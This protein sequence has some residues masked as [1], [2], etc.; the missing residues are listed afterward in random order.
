MEGEEL[1]SFL[2]DFFEKI[3]QDHSGVPSSEM[4]LHAG[5]SAK[6]WFCIAQP[7]DPSRGRSC[8]PFYLDFLRKACSDKKYRLQAYPHRSE[9]FQEWI[10]KLISTESYGFYEETEGV[11][12]LAVSPFSAEEIHIPEKGVMIREAVTQNSCEVVSMAV[13][14]YM[15]EVS[16][17]KTHPS[18]VKEELFDFLLQIKFF[19]NQLDQ[20]ATFFVLRGIK[21]ETIHRFQ[22]VDP[23]KHW[24]LDRIEDTFREIGNT[25][26]GSGTSLVLRTNAFTALHY[27]HASFSVQDAADYN[28]ISKNY[29]TGLYKEQAGIGFW[30]YVTK[31]RME[32]A[33]E[34]LLTSD[35]LIS[36][37]GSSVGYENEF[38]FSRKFKDF[39]GESPGQFRRI[40]KKSKNT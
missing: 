21:P 1:N 40:R 35:D 11:Y 39:T 17:R 29:F 26:F 27:H 8:E 5:Q 23:L 30:E 7:V 4:C 36:V 38:H 25:F 10:K 33:K 16:K 37:I 2:N 14:K 15:N 31:L 12:D 18:L 28:G 20:K 19:L 3:S 32:K 13:E 34:L 24:I 9:C 6:G 22:A